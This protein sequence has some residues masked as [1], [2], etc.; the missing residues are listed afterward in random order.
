VTLPSRVKVRRGH[1]HERLDPGGRYVESS[2]TAAACATR[3]Q[4]RPL[5]E[6]RATTAN[7]G[8]LLNVEFEP[9]LAQP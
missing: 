5:V 9:G 2:L 6:G 1:G 4:N 3:C 8:V 7:A